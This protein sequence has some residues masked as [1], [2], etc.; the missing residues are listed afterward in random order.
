M[1]ED[2]LYLHLEI[3]GHQFKIESITNISLYSILNEEK[4]FE[5]DFGG[6]GLTY[7]EFAP[8]AKPLYFL[9]IKNTIISVDAQQNISLIKKAYAELSFDLSCKIYDFLDVINLLHAQKESFHLSGHAESLDV[10]QHLAILKHAIYTKSAEY[11]IEVRNA[12]LQ[13]PS[14]SNRVP[15]C[16]VKDVNKL[17]NTSGVYCLHDTDGRYIYIGKSIHIKERVLSHFSARHQHPKEMKLFKETKKITFQKTNG[18]FGALLLESQLIKKYRPIYNRRLRRVAN[19]YSIKKTQDGLGYFSLE[20]KKVNSQS[21]LDNQDYFGL[22]RGVYSAKNYIEKI[23]TQHDLCGKLGGLEKTK[24][25]CFMYQLSR[26]FGACIGKESAIEYNAR[27]NAGLKKI[28]IS[29]WPF[30]SAIAIEEK[31]KDS[32]LQWHVFDK[33]CYLGSSKSLASAQAR[34]FEATALLNDI[35]A[36][37][38]LASYLK[39]HEDKIVVIPNTH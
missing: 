31:G 18:E 22:Y 25:A 4:V 5:V 17:P 21:I 7:Q 36:S 32:K 24:G 8:Y 23:V 30:S 35:D 39:Q 37:K 15:T 12:L 19:I 1:M 29:D 11:K 14:K 26:C 3:K 33:W 10:M 38:Y 16:L 13:L 27:L 20:V 9:L 6:N 34:R 28:T 2:F